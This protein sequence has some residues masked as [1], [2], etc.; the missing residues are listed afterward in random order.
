MLAKITTLLVAVLHLVFMVV[1]TFLWTTPAVRERFG[2]SVEQAE[3]TRVLAANQGVYNGALGL[4]LA[5]AALTGNTTVAKVLLLFV[6]V[7][8]LYGG[9]TAKPS[10][11]VLQALPAAIALLF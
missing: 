10:I 8:G 5:W 6:I 1:E 9:A 7:V 2:T 3:T 11:F 4:A